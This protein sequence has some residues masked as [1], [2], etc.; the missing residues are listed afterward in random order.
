[1]PASSSSFNEVR[2]GGTV[3]DENMLKIGKR[4][5]TK[6]FNAG[7]FVYAQS[8]D[9]YPITQEL[10]RAFVHELGQMVEAVTP[11]ME[12][13]EGAQALSVIE[14]FFW[15]QFTDN[16]LELVKARA[17]GEE[18]TPPE[19]AGSAVAGLRLGMN[20][21]LRLFAPF[22][23]YI[24]EEAWSWI[25]ADETG[26]ASIHIAPWPGPADFDGLAPPDDATSLQ[27]AT[28]CLAEIRK[29]KADAE[30]SVGRPMETITI[31]AEA[32]TLARLRPVAADVMDAARAQG[33]TLE[34]KASVRSG[35]FAVVEAMFVA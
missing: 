21:L 10:D 16:Y 33:Y 13:Y 2:V 15:R 3:L 7:K 22:L 32:A 24:T 1:M 23:P 29:H 30:V 28:A 25:A 35:A 27:T 19:A 5:V 4:L 26:Y 20:V 9:T 6:L 11:M 18:G 14:D 12:A 17:R 31:A 8:A 34:E